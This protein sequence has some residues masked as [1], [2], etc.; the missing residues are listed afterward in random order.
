MSPRGRCI[1][2]LQSDVVLTDEH[3]FPEAAGG[4]IKRPILCKPCNSRLGQYVDAAY[5]KQK[6]V[7][8]ARVTY[9]IAGKTGQI[10]QPFSDTHIVEVPE[11][12]LKIQLDQDFAPRT[13]PQA[14]EVSVTENREIKIALSVDAQDRKKL[15]KILKTTLTRFFKTEAGQ[16]LGW[17]TED[18]ARAIQR[19]IEQAEQSESR[20][21]HISKPLQGRWTIDLKVL[22]AELVK[23]V[24][25]ISCLEFG[26]AFLDTDVAG[27]MRAF[28]LA[29]CSDDPTPWSLPDM[30]RHLHMGISELP[31]A[32]EEITQHLCRGNRSVYHLAIVT[33]TGVVCSMFNIT[34]VFFPPDLARLGVSQDTMPTYVNSIRDDDYGV[35]P[36]REALERVSP[37]LVA[38]RTEISLALRLLRSIS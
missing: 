30:Q 7:E 24:Y 1:L 27:K 16:A 6:L 9:R 12:T 5:V 20:S 18:Q 31:A 21:S 28:L 22:Y 19:S 14:P 35:F 23:V 25:E 3:I 13:I 33:P 38:P 26:P 4:R 34:A 32:L 15:P 36:L 10:P 8:L 17:S 37:G 2:C 11:G 29:Q